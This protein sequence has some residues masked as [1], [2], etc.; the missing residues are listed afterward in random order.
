MGKRVALLLD[1]GFG[2]LVG[3]A[4]SL[5]RMRGCL[6][7]QGFKAEA[8]SGPQVTRRQ[9]AAALAAHRR[10][11]REG[12]SFALYFVGHG[13]RAQGPPRAGRMGEPP[14][15]TDVL[16][17]VTHDLFADP[18]S[19]PGIAGAELLEWLIPIAETTGDVTLILD[20]C[21][22]ATMTTGLSELDDA[23]RANIAEA[24]ARSVPR[25]RA[26][27]GIAAP[28]AAPE[29]SIVRLVA[30]TASDIAVEQDVPGGIGRIGL[31]TDALAQVLS[32]QGAAR[33]SWDELLPEIQEHVLARCS[34]QRPGLEGPRHRIPFSRDERSPIDR[35][36]CISGRGTSTLLAGALHGIDEG[37]RF[38]LGPFTATAEAVGADQARLRLDGNVELPRVTTVRR[39]GC[40]RRQSVTLSS[41]DP[42]LDALLRAL[43]EVPELTLDDGPATGSVTW[44]ND[45]LVLRDRSGTVVHA[46]A[47]ARALA[48]GCVARLVAA[49][50]RTARWERQRAV[51]EAFTDPL[52][53]VAWGCVGDERSLDSEGVELTEGT[54]LWVRAWGRGEHPEVFVSLFH[55]RG[56]QT[57]AHIGE[58]LDHG[59]PVP[60]NRSVELAVPALGLSW[61]E[62]VPRSSP[63]N[64]ALWLVS[65]PRPRALHRVATDIIERPSTALPRISRGDG[66]APLL[67]AARLGFRLLP[68]AP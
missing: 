57:F 59:V 68:R 37:D 49:I 44:E 33:R 14:P 34:T 19:A 30:T 39:V 32:G 15:S 5:E 41:L 60:R 23:A 56:D 54:S 50:R 52:V 26:K 28:R 10:G 2:T 36:L 7:G 38:E 45:A 4:N 9:V 11:L 18:A 27:Y 12:D 58:C 40:A 35:Y 3:S 29:T 48:P 61:P 62:W 51:L 17:L 64:E 20:C 63:C 24:L 47:N 1:C 22:A 55:L 21:R 66:E 8:M 31:F 25:L 46:E 43:A 65:S 67:G 53:H 16:F 13:E 6:E 42:P